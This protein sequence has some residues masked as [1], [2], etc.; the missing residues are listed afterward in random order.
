[1]SRK[2]PAQPS[3]Q[4]EPRVF[5]EPVPIEAVPPPKPKP[6]PATPAPAPPDPLLAL[7]A[8]GREQ[9]A[10]DRALIKAD[11][12]MADRERDRQLADEWRRMLAVASPH[13]RELMARVPATPP[14]DFNPTSGEWVMAHLSPLRLA[15]VCVRVNAAKDSDRYEAAKTA[16][17]APGCAMGDYYIRVVTFALRRDED[18]E[19]AVSS[20]TF[21]KWLGTHDPITAL[22]LAEESYRNFERVTA[23]AEELNRIEQASRDGDKPSR[24]CTPAEA[25]VLDALQTFVLAA[26]AG[27]DG[28]E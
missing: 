16:C 1:M 11:V 4:T 25:A 9:L 13:L 19:W 7:L 26:E 27:S 10:Q 23:E 20:N 15:P 8:R 12:D 14:E 3:S 5:H 6:E 28:D 18:L 17:R 21:D 22:A 2:F 24:T